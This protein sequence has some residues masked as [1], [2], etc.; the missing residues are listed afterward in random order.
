[1]EA[2]CPRY[3]DRKKPEI[4]RDVNMASLSSVKVYLIDRAIKLMS[5]LKRLLKVYF[6]NENT[7]RGVSHQWISDIG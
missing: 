3:E 5:L 4:P 6:H 1:M 2:T 7:Y